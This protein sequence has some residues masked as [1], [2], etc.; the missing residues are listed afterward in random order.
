M[1][2][3]YKIT[4]NTETALREVLALWHLAMD[5][6]MLVNSGMCSSWE[7]TSPEKLS[8]VLVGSESDNKRLDEYIL[9][10]ERAVDEIQELLIRATEVTEILHS[11]KTTVA[12][13]DAL[14][15]KYWESKREEKIDRE[16][17]E[18]TV[19]IKEAKTKS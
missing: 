17:E 10:M 13:R 12:T 11:L 4:S 19:D 8:W 18:P 1:K 14:E 16:P 3:N 6:A 5:R 9:K 7:A 15:D 2:V